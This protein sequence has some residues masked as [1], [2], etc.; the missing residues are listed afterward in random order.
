MTEKTSL[1]LRMKNQAIEDSNRLECLSRVALWG[2]VLQLLEPSGI[3]A[4]GNP[5]AAIGDVEIT[6]S[7]TCQGQDTRRR[8]TNDPGPE[9]TPTG[10]V[11]ELVELA[12]YPLGLA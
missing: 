7:D 6:D 8:Q 10:V 9:I 11:R 2:R 4:T 12:M 3:L 5:T 1:P